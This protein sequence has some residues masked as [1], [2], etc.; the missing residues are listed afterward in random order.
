MRKMKNNENILT[1]IIFPVTFSIF[2]TRSYQIAREFQRERLQKLTA[3]KT[4]ILAL[5]PIL[6]CMC[7][8]ESAFA[9][10]N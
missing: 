8:G 2:Y 7:V 9:N 1:T 3:K 4:R 5:M 6:R 10:H